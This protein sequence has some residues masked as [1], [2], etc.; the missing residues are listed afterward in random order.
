[1]ICL[2]ACVCVCVCCSSEGLGDMC[3]CMCVCVDVCACVCVVP[4]CWVML[5]WR[6]CLESGIERV[7]V[8]RDSVYVERVR[9]HRK[10]SCAHSESVCTQAV[11]VCVYT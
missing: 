5:A 4:C 3:A 6:A 11:Y 2:H 8:H 1:M 10:C 9:V 7:D